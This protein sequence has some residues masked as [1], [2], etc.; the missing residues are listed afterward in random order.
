MNSSAH[1]EFLRRLKAEMAGAVHGDVFTRGRYA[2]DASIYQMMPAAVAIPRDVED[3]RTA[4]ALAREFELPVTPRGGGTSQCGQTVNHGLV[5]DNSPHLNALLELDVERQRCVVQPGIVLDELNRLLKPHGLWFPVDVSTASRATIGGMAANNSCGQRSIHYGTMRHNVH[6]MDAILPSGEPLRFDEV[7]AS[8]EGVTGGR[9]TFIEGLLS[10]GARESGNIQKRFPTVLR[11]VGGYNIDAL[12]PYESVDDGEQQA[13]SHYR[14]ADLLVGSEGT[15]AYSTAIELKLWPL[16]QQRVLGICHFPGFHEAMDAT[17]HLVELGPH[18]IE[19][20]DNTMVALARDIELYRNSVAEFVRGDPAALLIVEFAFDS[21]AENLQHLKLLHERMADLGFTWKGKGKNW[22]GV[23]EAVDPAL[24]ARIGEVRKA[25]LNIMM[26]MK[27]EGKPV[28]FVEDCAVDLPDLADY[29]AELTEVFNRHGTPGTW[30]AHA[31]VGCLH[32]RPVLNMKLEK[33]ANTMREIAEEAFDLVLKYKG[34]HSGEHGDG[35]SRSE[36]HTKMFGEQMVKAFAEIKHRFDPHNLFNP[37]KIVNA[38]R[39]NDRELFRYR[40]G[41]RMIE[42]RQQLDWSAWPG[43]SG[44]LQGAIEMCNNNGACRKMQG[45]VMC[46]SY[47][48]TRDEQ[49]VTRGRANTLRLAMSGQLGEDAMS[50]DAMQETMKLCVSCK[51]CQR[52]CP[53][54]VDMAKMKMEVM[55]ARARVHGYTLHQK[56]VAHL[57]RY[58]AV[59]SRFRTLLNLRNTLPGV[60]AMTESLSGFS[61]RRRLPVWA[62]RPFVETDTVGDGSKEVV[63]LAD[64]FNTWFEPDNLR[65]ARVVLQAAGYRVHLAQAPGQRKLCCGRTY[66]ATGMIEQARLEAGRMVAALLPWIDRGLPVVG[67]EP[68]CLLTLR[69][70]Y[71]ALLPGADTDRLAENALL[72]EELIIRDHEAG[73]LEWSLSAPV[74]QVLVHGHCHQKALGAFSAVQK[75]LALIPGMAVSVIDSSCC[76]MA[77]AFGYGRDTCDVSM[78]MAELSLLPAVRQADTETLVVA[79]GTSCRHQIAEGASRDAIHVVQVLAMA[80]RPAES[81]GGSV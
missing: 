6:A 80:L 46:P 33:D 74:S 14:L 10:L 51:A 60:A 71:K 69:D 31:S 43:A 76:G 30:Y 62:A 50:S 4:L 35:I 25:G 41:Y 34:S 13:R 40:P 54:G 42:I 65:A 63:L 48:V 11:R 68:S 58:A 28:S 7:P 73:T 29:T 49:H 21:E 57:P 27:E 67:L 2:T 17:Q 5:L 8:L 23:V 78:K 72:L 66:L 45:G 9:R 47:R 77:G 20:V 52:E 56:L 44:G 3:V 15:L 55:A 53:T 12:M 38:P 59:A 64:T 22:G 70:E 24:Q 79:D 37:G 26:S 39:M 1:P 19:L 81:P 18:A 75:T 16:P 36:F 32:V 61:A